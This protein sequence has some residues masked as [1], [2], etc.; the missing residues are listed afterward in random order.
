VTVFKVDLMTRT[1]AAGALVMGM[2]LSVL[3]CGGSSSSSPTTPSGTTSGTGSHN[4]GKNCLSC[5]SFTAAGTVYKS[6]GTTAY[7]GAVIRLTT[8]SG[9]GG[10]LVAALTAD[11]SGNVYTN[12]SINFGTGLYVT[13]TGTGG[14]TTPMGPAITSGACNNCHTSGN[15][16]KVG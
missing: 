7:P 8:A 5:H 11:P 13:A 14:A 2:A 12:A 9:G 15:R 4:A 3:A 1:L 10:T 6:D 16:I